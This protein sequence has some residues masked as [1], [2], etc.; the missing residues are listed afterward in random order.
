MKTEQEIREQGVV[1]AKENSHS[2]DDECNMV[3]GYIAGYKA[4][5]EQQV[6][7]KATEYGN[8]VA[9]GAEI[10]EKWMKAAAKYDRIVEAVENHKKDMY[11]DHN[12]L[13]YTLMQI[14]N[15]DNGKETEAV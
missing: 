11:S 4:C 1:W 5:E 9:E 7:D 6:W 14:I 10:S 15:E 12:H 13:L 2:G 3:D 8:G